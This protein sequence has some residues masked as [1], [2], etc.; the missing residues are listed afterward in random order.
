[1]GVGLNVENTGGHEHHLTLQHKLSLHECST[2]CPRIGG[3][4]GH[5]S[6]APWF[7]L[8][9]LAQRASDAEVEPS[10]ETYQTT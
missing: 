7:K 5:K 2:L 6:G 1:M 9:V 10:A 4:E 3:P 8:A